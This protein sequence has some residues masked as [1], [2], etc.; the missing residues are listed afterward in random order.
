MLAGEGK[1]AACI[2][3]DLFPNVLPCLTAEGDG[4]K[5]PVAG[6]QPMESEA[7]FRRLKLPAD[8]IAS[9]AGWGVAK[10]DPRL[11]DKVIEAA[12]EDPFAIAYATG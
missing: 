2:A 6:N 5:A 12:G 8:V 7:A 4:Y 9:S 10:S 3:R 11:F 1:L